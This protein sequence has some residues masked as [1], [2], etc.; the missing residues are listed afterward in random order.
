MNEKGLN[1]H[2]PENA[3]QQDQ[4]YDSVQEILAVVSF[5]WF[6]FHSSTLSVNN[7]H[8][9]GCYDFYRIMSEKN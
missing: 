7:T 2:V 8:R 3:K 4:E 1:F 5:N 9:N 6:V